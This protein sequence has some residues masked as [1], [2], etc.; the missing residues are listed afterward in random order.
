MFSA[1]KIGVLISIAIAAFFVL[2]VWKSLQPLLEDRQDRAEKKRRQSRRA[3]KQPAAAKD[4]GDA[5][6]GT[7]DLVPC[8][9]CGAFVPD[10]VCGCKG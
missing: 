10:G 6:S 7:V 9:R 1:S 4:N 8:K 3:E 5:T 2:R